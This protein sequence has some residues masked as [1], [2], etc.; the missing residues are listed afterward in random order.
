M[1][2]RERPLC[3]KVFYILVKRFE[4]WDVWITRMHF[5]YEYL[6]ENRGITI[7]SK[8]A[9]CTLGGVRDHAFGYAWT[10]GLFCRDGENVAGS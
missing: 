3:P 7:F 4:S 2:M 1:W 10:C 9:E 5:R 8:Q 6:R